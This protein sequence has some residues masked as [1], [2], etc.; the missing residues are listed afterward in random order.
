MIRP[1]S[2]TVVELPSQQWLAERVRLCKSRIQAN[3]AELVR[4]FS[5]EVPIAQIIRARSDFM[6]DILI[7]TWKNITAPFAQSLALVAVGGYGR[8]ELHLHSDIDLLILVDS[9][10]AGAGQMDEPS[11]KSALS[12]FF[13]FLWDIGIKP[14]QSTRTIDETA[15]QA[16]ADQTVMTNLLEA[17]LLDGPASLFQALLNRLLPDQLWPSSE[18][19]AAKMKEQVSRHAKYYDTAYTLEPNVKEGPGGLRDIQIIGWIIKRHYGSSD[20]RELIVHGWLTETEFAELAETRNFLWRV[21]FA[22]HALTGRG[23]DRLLFDYQRE[24]AHRFGYRGDTPNEAVEQFMQRY[25]RSV[26]GLERLNE[27]VLQLF[28]EVVLHSGEGNTIMPIN[29]SFQAV[30][31]YLEATHAKVLDRKSVV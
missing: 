18:F 12:A 21:R 13:T 9:H 31:H 15:E 25:F 16:C 28:D 4:Q 19:F 8:Q 17:R 1:V 27:M 5:A 10:S 29:E 20:L 14:A 26:M 24:L 6:D 3:G 2:S 7:G 11:Y 23:E 22:L 30:N